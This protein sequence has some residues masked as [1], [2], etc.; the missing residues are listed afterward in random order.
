MSLGS[1]K[2][3][4]DL[5]WSISA[6]K[7]A[8]CGPSRGSRGGESDLGK[9]WLEAVLAGEPLLAATGEVETSLLDSR[10]EVEAGGPLGDL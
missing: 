10:L 2:F 8:Y 5:K 4:T 6:A 9:I 7:D 3:R 1:A